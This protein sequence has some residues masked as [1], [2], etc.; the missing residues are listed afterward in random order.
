MESQKKP[1]SKRTVKASFTNPEEIKKKREEVLHNVLDK[2]MRLKEALGINDQ[3]ME[4]LYSHGYQLYKIGKY[5]EAGRMFHMLYLLNAA[6]LRF[7]M[8]IAACYHMQKEYL[9]ASD[10]Y[11][12]C[13]AL[14]QLSPLP[15]YH[16]SDCLY[17]MNN[18]VGAL[19]VLKMM[20]GRLTD[21]PKYKVIKERANRMTEA[22][23]KELSIKQ[24]PE[25]KAP[26]AP[27]QEKLK[28]R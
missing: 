20:Q 22:L 25:T 6:D 3:T 18:K 4:Y 10:W 2:K 26:A 17:K 9:L 27:Q 7:S 12:V 8:G 14:D 11:F 13:A 5:K 24:L 15:Y 23:S 21:D 1:S 16:I 28:A 19:I